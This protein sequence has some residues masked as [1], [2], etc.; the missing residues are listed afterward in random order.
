M[1]QMRRF[2]VIS[3]VLMSALFISYTPAFS[4]EGQGLKL[5]TPGDAQTG[6]PVPEAAGEETL[7]IWGEVISV[8]TTLG[9]ILVR[10]LDYETGNEVNITIDTESTT[11]YENVAALA[12]IKPKDTVSIDYIASGN[13]NLAKNISVEKL[14]ATPEDLGAPSPGAGMPESESPTATNY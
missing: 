12:E 11:T 2:Y 7:W 14:E 10:Y 9:Q 5:E 3:L 6:A 4:Q 13:K 8:D 1:R